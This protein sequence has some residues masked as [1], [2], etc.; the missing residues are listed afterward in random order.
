MPRRYSSIDSEAQPDLR[1]RHLTA[2]G[3]RSRPAVVVIILACLVFACLALP[4]WLNEYVPLVDYPTHLARTEI[5]YRYDQVPSFRE[6]YV[7]DSRLIPNLA[8]DLVVPVLRH[9]F[10]LGVSGKIFLTAMLTLY[11]A[12]TVALSKVLYARVALRAFLVWPMFY[13][14]TFLWGFVNYVAGVC[15]FI[16][17]C[18]LLL[19]TADDTHKKW[20]IL[21]YALLIVGA[22]ACY[23]AHL[24]AFMLCCA[25]WMMLVVREIVVE[26]RISRQL[27]LC[28]LA[29]PLPALHYL[30]LLTSGHFMSG[31][32]ITAFT[33]DWR[34]K[35]TQ[36]AAFSRGYDWRE[37]LLPTV[38]L[39]GA[40]SYCLARSWRRLLISPAGWIALGL[41]AAFLLL[42]KQGNASTGSGFDVRFFW[43]AVV[44]LVFAL[45]SRGWSSREKL[46]VAL[47]AGSAWAVRLAYLESNW[48]KLSNQSSQIVSLFDEIPEGSRIYSLCGEFAASDIGKRDATLCHVVSYGIPRRHLVDLAFFSYLGA[49]PV[50]FRTPPRYSGMNR[51]ERII[52][53]DYVWASAESADADASTYL[54]A[55]ADRIGEVSGYILWR[56]PGAADHSRQLSGSPAAH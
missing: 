39:L 31:P 30:S 46:L 9:Y 34:P 28:G 33:F 14:S 25:A 50:I 11:C 21:R 19:R 40:G 49:Q 42:P 8:I 2:P 6:T 3:Y 1:S 51:F 36:L 20:Q 27:L 38:L 12:G 37:D 23:A 26:K 22:V 10:S 7:I 35:V 55:H 29:F 4:I 56:M 43:P 53:A 18:A 32:E 44:F 52:N 15:I 24:A 13:D 41:F 54:T 17:W 47:L 48:H 5:L 45:P 16:A